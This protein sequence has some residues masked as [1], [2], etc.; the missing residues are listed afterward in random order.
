MPPIPSTHGAAI[1]LPNASF[2]SPTT[3]FVD[4]RVDGWQKQPKPFWF[5]E[6]GGNFWDQLAGIFI[7]PPEGSEGHIENSDG[8]QALY[9][10][11]V[12]QNG[13][14]QDYDS[15]DWAHTEPTHDF[16]AIF[17][18]GKSY[19]LT[20]GLKGGGGGMREG[21]SLQLSL[22]Y[23][24]ANG[25]RAVVAST[26]VTHSTSLF[27]TTTRFLDFAATTPTLEAGHP[28]V[29]KRMGVALDTLVAPELAAGYWDLDNVRLESN[30]DDGV[31]L[32]HTRVQGG[33][34]LRWQTK[35]GWEYQLRES[36]DLVNWTPVG[37]GQGGTGGDLSHTVSFESTGA[38]FYTLEISPEQL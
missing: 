27:P 7:N 4:L 31:Q 29:G 17:E 14:F 35:R 19:T 34:E 23:R 11:A 22:Y 30:G 10:F 26:V 24:E 3:Q 32:R 12:P 37:P 18:A 8:S 2:E 13:L 25:G 1:H 9:L 33:M 28:A 15:V 16:D 20:V 21:S 38:R 36:E 5:D 6:S